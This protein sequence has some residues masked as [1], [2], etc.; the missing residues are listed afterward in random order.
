MPYKIH[1][2]RLQTVIRM[3]IEDAGYAGTPSFNDGR[4]V[5]EEKYKYRVYED[6]RRELEYGAA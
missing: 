6:A 1:E 5:E 2:E 4:F 3:L